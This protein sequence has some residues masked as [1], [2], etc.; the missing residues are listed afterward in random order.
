MKGVDAVHVAKMIGLFC[1][2]W[3]LLLGSF[4]KE[5]YN[6]KEP[7]NRSHPILSNVKGVDAYIKAV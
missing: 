6:F 4:A 2:I 7:T 3:S 1:R 5:T